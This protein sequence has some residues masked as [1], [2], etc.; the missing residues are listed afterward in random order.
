[1]NKKMMMKKKSVKEEKEKEKKKQCQ[2]NKKRT[3]KEVKWIR[4]RRKILENSRCQERHTCVH[5]DPQNM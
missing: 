3:E 5:I 2:R 1:M 4:Y